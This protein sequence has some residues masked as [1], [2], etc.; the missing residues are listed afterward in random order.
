MSTEARSSAVCNTRQ[1]LLAEGRH[2]QRVSL[3]SRM[4]L[5]RRLG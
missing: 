3:G 4:S 2:K 1:D 5:R